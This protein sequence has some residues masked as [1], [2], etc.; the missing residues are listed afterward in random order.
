MSIGAYQIEINGK[1]YVG[2][3]TQG[4]TKRM[5]VHLSA[6]RRGIHYNRYLQRAFNEYGEDA[7]RFSTLEVVE[8]PEE[9]ILL[10]QKYIDEIKPEYNIRLTAGNTLGRKHTE[11][12]KLKISVSLL[13]N[14]YALGY[15]HTDETKLKISIANLGHS[16]TEEHKEKLLATHKGK[17][18]SEE[19]RAKISAA[20][21]GRKQT[22]EH[23][24][25]AHAAR[26]GKKLSDETKARIRAAKL[27][28]KL[29]DEHREK[30][31]AGHKQNT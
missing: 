26:K 30:I 17:S 7:L 21:L 3:T 28:K 16:L 15:C 8:T 10:E 11:E 1:R 20:L 27:G 6:L 4:F 24:A 14:T 29:S 18:L 9:C 19:T 12:Q 31:I 13:G 2:S 22:E 23:I 25:K 5:A